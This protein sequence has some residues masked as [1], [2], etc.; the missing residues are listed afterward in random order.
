MKEKDILNAMNELDDEMLLDAAPSGAQRKR[1]PWG[2]IGTVAACAAVLLAGA[3]AAA[4]Y[5]SGDSPMETTADLTYMDTTREPVNQYAFADNKGIFTPWIE[6]NTSEALFVSESHQRVI[7]NER[8][9]SYQSNHVIDEKY[10]GEKIEE[11]EVKAYW[12]HHSSKTETDVEYLTAEVYRIKDVDPSVA[13]CVKYLEPCDTLTMTH[14]Y[15]FTNDEVHFETISE[16][17]TLYSAERYIFLRENVLIDRLVADRLV[18]TMYNCDTG[19]TDEIK[20]VLL[21]LTANKR[22]LTEDAYAMIFNESSM[23]VRLRI[24]LISWGI[25][26]YPMFITDGGYLLMTWY[27]TNV[28]FDI[29]KENANAIIDLIKNEGDI[30]TYDDQALIVETTQR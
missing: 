1:L 26:N 25:V 2:R 9:A 20:D 18:Y 8:Y 22:Y 21:S 27:G 23:Q 15:T 10:V 12:Y 3:F 7:T 6:A 17:F 24:D 29:G 5:L 13:V 30:Y 4:P 11:V 19:T 16:L 28:Y 14:Y